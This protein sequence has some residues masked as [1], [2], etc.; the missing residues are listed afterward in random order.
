MRA[1]D[2][3]VGWDRWRGPVPV[4]F[5][6]HPRYFVGALRSRTLYF[7]DSIAVIWLIRWSVGSV[8][9]KYSVVTPAD[10]VP[11]GVVLLKM[12][13]LACRLVQPCF[14]MCAARPWKYV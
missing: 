13:G 12:H 11:V 5:M 4:I 9:K 2:I 14:C 1:L 7:F 6:I 8:T 3:S 10:M